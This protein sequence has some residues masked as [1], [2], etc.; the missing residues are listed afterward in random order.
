MTDLNPLPMTLTLADVM[1]DLESGRTQPLR[2]PHRL[3]SLR[4]RRRPAAG[5]PAFLGAYAAARMLGRLH[6]RL[7]RRWLMRLW[8]TP[9]VHR[10]ARRPVIDLPA[11]LRPWSLAHDGVTLHGF[12]GGTGPTAVLVHGWAGRAA[13]W[14]YLASDLI[15]AG[16]RIVAPDLPAHGTTAG[17]TTDAFTLGRAAAAVLRH[18]RPTGIVAHSMGFPITLLAFDE[19]AP[20]PEVLVALAPGRRMRRALTRFGDQAKLA[21]AL[22]D[23]LYLANQRRFGGD[24]WDV[25]DVDRAVGDLAARGLIV[26]DGGDEDVP[27]ADGEHIAAQWAD[28]IFVATEG[29]GHRRILRDDAVRRLVV[30][31]LRQPLE[32][33]RVA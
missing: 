11:D 8:L 16:F 13:D 3:L 31:A 17:R 30:A 14:R 24:V 28:A 10:S 19:Q 22:L 27:I 32:D 21:P 1:R 7:A 23:E 18:E 2:P 12:A 25:L 26:H 15:E 29:L 20:P 33:H 9:W 4:A 5:G 6:P